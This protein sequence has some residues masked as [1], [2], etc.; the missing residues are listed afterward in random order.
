MTPHLLLNGLSVTQRAKLTAQTDLT[1]RSSGALSVAALLWWL[2]S[3][4]SRTGFDRSRRNL[5]A[6]SCGCPLEISN[7]R[8]SM[9]TRKSKAPGLSRATRTRIS[10]YRYYR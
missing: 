1:C 5:E 8:G 6:Q 2:H 9:Q 7:R 10:A 3:V 4:V